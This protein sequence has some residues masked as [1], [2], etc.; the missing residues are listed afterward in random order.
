MSILDRLKEHWVGALVALCAIV[1]AATWKVAWELHVSPRD[2]QIAQLKDD[3]AREK[4]DGAVHQSP[5]GEPAAQTSVIALSETGVFEGSS[6]TTSDGRVAVKITQV[7]GDV[8]SL[9]ITL[10]AALPIEFKKQ[11]IGSRIAVD[12]GSLTYFV[13]LQRVR[14]NIVDIIISRHSK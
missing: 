7:L 1:A 2:F 3:L 10:D 9:S 8:V 11:A 4:N 5:S 13:D 6:A 14:G 12:A